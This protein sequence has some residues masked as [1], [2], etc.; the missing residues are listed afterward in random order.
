MVKTPTEHRVPRKKDEEKHKKKKKK[1]K[2]KEG[3]EKPTPNEQGR[4]IMT[5][6]K[7]QLPSAI[8]EPQQLG[9]LEDALLLLV[10][11]K[12]HFVQDATAP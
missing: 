11:V 1:R 12:R 8:F 2:K 5:S 9:A 6:T 10:L 3:G 4:G 7:S